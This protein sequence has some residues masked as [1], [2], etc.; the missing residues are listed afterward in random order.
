MATLR[1]ARS[2][3]QAMVSE[4][5][6]KQYRL[7]PENPDGSLPINVADRGADNWRERETCSSVAQ[8]RR[9]LEQLAADDTAFVRA[10]ERERGLHNDFVPVRGGNEGH[11]LEWMKKRA[12][13]V[14]KEATAQVGAL[15]RPNYSRAGKYRTLYEYSRRGTRTRWSS[16]SGSSKTCWVSHC[17]TRRAPTQRGGRRQTAA[18][19]RFVAQMRGRWPTERRGRVSTQPVAFERIP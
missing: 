13:T 3:R 15:T 4:R 11:M 19:L 9:R 7:G 1:A 10:A 2:D 18:R 12:S 17:R 16:R 14:H 8:A 5:T 6:P